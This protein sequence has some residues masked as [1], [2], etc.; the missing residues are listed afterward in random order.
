MTSHIKCCVGY[1]VRNELQL[2][3]GYLSS[4]IQHQHI[5]QLFKAVRKNYDFKATSCT[6]EVASL[7]KKLA[8]AE[9]QLKEEKG[10][11][12]LE[13][14]NDAIC[15]RCLTPWYWLLDKSKESPVCVGCGVLKRTG[16]E[17]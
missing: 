6:C 11:A 7:T 10:K 13:R 16:F 2:P 5:E 14:Y 17:A 9:K 4:G 1:I 12:K 15:S 8:A 3:D